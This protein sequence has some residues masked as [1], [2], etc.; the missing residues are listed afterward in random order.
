MAPLSYYPN[1]DNLIEV[2]AFLS[3]LTFLGNE[4][5]CGTSE[6]FRQPLSAAVNRFLAE[7]FIYCN[8]SGKPRDADDCQRTSPRSVLSVQ[9]VNTA[10]DI[11]GVKSEARE[12]QRRRQRRR[13]WR[14]RR[15]RRR[16]LHPLFFFN[17][18]PLDCRQ[19][20][21]QLHSNSCEVLVSVQVAQSWSTEPKL[22]VLVLLEPRLF[23]LSFL[24]QIT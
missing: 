19:G 5:I 13:R 3:S 21:S 11:L 15:W 22:W 8:W 18:E 23:S 7:T 12:H 4:E 17:R 10:T 16:H 9:R 2:S 1:P 20:A 14:W 6:K 24:Q